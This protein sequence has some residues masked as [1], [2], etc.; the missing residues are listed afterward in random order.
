[1]Y[2][3]LEFSYWVSTD[4]IVAVEDDAE[5]GVSQSNCQIELLP[6]SEDDSL[7][8]HRFVEILQ[9]IGEAHL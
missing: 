4:D 5:I 9:R 6:K 3:S 1:M 2:L 8:E 7:A